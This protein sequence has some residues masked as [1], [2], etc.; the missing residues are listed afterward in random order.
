MVS[1]DEYL[2]R[3]VK[4]DKYF[5][6]ERRRFLHL[7][8]VKKVKFKVFDSFYENTYLLKPSS[9]SFF[10]LFNTPL[11]LSTTVPKAAG[12]SEIFRNPP[13]KCTF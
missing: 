5:L 13:V 4:S 9:E 2:L 6:N 12:D 10:P 3:T 7:C 11:W 1:R 8:D